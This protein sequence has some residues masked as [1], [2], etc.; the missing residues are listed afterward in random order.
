MLIATKFFKGPLHY[1]NSLIIEKKTAKPN[2]KNE[3]LR[4]QS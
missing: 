3:G 1:G 4:Q 2:I